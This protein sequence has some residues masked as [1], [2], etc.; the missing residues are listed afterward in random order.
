MSSAAKNPAVRDG[1]RAGAQPPPLVFSVPFTG[2]SNE[3]RRS[4]PIMVAAIVPLVLPLSNLCPSGATEEEA[5]DRRGIHPSTPA[6]GQGF[7]QG[8]QSGRP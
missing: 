2:K 5:A 3:S 1:R 8:I 6:I 7:D 4:V